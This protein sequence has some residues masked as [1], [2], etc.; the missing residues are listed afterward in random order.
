MNFLAKQRKS[1]EKLAD[2]VKDY[3]S[4]RAADGVYH[5]TIRTTDRFGRKVVVLL[6][7]DIVGDER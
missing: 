1:R 5:D 4:L 7:L 2:A 6:R 3:M